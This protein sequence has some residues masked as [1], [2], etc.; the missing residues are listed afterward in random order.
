[1][2]EYAIIQRRRVDKIRSNRRA[3]SWIKLIIICSFVII[4]T[5]SNAKTQLNSLNVVF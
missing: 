4:E 3:F 1:M 2:E 5:A